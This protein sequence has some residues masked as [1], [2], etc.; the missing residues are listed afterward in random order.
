MDRLDMEFFQTTRW[1]IVL[2]AGRSDSTQARSA[3]AELCQ[4]YWYPL[5][6][7]VRRQGHQAHDA[8]DLTQSFFTRLLEKHALD[9][10]D[11]EKGKF[12]SFL[13]ASLKNFMANEWD[14][15]QAQK[16]G[17]QSTLSLDHDSAESRYGLEP[18]HELSAERIFERRWAMTLLDHAFA[19]LRNEYETEGKG[20][21]FQALKGTLTAESGSPTYASISERLGTTEG[22]IKVAAHRLRHRFRDVIRAEIAQTVASVEDVDDELRHLLS[23]LGE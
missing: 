20:D 4:S 17:G 18:S 1:T 6:A 5:Y 15:G 7:F 12:R 9:Q 11:R 8:Q 2:N 10:V 23:V 22:A 16:R 3:L 19:T 13:L 21:L 14:K